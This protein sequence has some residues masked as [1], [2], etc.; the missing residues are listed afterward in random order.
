MGLDFSRLAPF[1]E[2][3]LLDERLSRF[4]V[5]KTGRAAVTTQRVNEA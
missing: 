3:R 1:P 5:E 4:S 2:F